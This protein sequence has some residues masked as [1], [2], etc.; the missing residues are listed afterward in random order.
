M[1]LRIDSLSVRTAT[2]RPLLEDVSWE[3][4]TVGRLGLIGESGSGKSLTAQAVLGLLPEGMHATGSIT[5]DGE[6]LLGRGERALRAV[7]GRRIAMVFQ[8]PLTALDPLMP[9]GRQISGP[10]RLHTPLRGAAAQRRVRELLEMVALRESER[11]LRS[12][13][14]ELSGG[15][16]QRV[17]LAMALACE[18]EVLIADEP[19]TA[20]DVTV[21]DEILTLLAGLIERTGVTLVFVSH[22]LPVVA[23]VAEDLVVMREGKV[24]ETGPAARLLTSPSSDYARSLVTAARAVTALPTREEER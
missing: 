4:P 20:L 13:P 23:R 7:R 21:Q 9:V 2:G 1:S 22:D 10:L 24:V 19:T 11:I 16:R 6:E 17:A 8:E 3:V 14:W 18:P 12:Y 15:Q 5:L